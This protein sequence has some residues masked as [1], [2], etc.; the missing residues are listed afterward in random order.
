VGTA[1]SFQEAPF[2]SVVIPAYREEKRLPAT[3]AGLPRELAAAGIL[4]Y[5][6]IVVDDG[7]PDGTADVV[8]RAAEE[9]P[10]IRLV[11][12]EENRGKGRAVRTGAL[13]AR[14]EWVLTTD[15]DGSTPASDVARLIAV[16]RRGVPV[17]VGSRRVK[18]AK[19]AVRQ[20]LHREALG[21]A[22]AG[23]RRLLVLPTIAD[24]QCGF[25][26]F[27]ADAARALFFAARE[28]GFVY[29]VE[30]L[31]LARQR[32]LKSVE[33]PVRWADDPRTQVRA[34]PA[35]AS[36][37]LGLLRLAL[38]RIAPAPSRGRRPRRRRAP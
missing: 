29:D 16:G 6:A 9:N 10:R 36:M 7:S 31:L 27:R 13:V 14:G 1:G 2:L 4:S 20:P 33:V 17:V 18:G 21:F 22:F 3:L 37:A 23:L 8:R 26:L 11:R 30:V 12:H 28:D 32:G 34:L 19:I 38:R 5:E 25:K 24:T 15:A 35:S